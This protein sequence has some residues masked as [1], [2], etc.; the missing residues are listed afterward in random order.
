MTAMARNTCTL[1]MLLHAPHFSTNPSPTGNQDSFWIKEKSLDLRPTRT[2]HGVMKLRF[3]L[4]RRRVSR[5][6]PFRCLDL[7]KAQPVR[8]ALIFLYSRET[9][10][11][12]LPSSDE[13]TWSERPISAV[14]LEHQVHLD[15]EFCAKVSSTKAGNG[16]SQ[17]AQIA[18]I[19]QRQTLE[20]YTGELR[21]R[22]KPVKVQKNRRDNP[23]GTVL[24]LRKKLEKAPEQLLKHRTSP[25][26]RRPPAPIY[27]L[28]S[29]SRRSS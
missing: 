7:A 27:L 3:D 8:A 11:G 13:G 18:R 15:R 24:A 9:T 21:T 25:C 26:D 29:L 16:K 6:R 2:V 4:S 5:S 22:H 12:A 23:K 1:K 19:R 28:V 10:E 17:P 20:A 14:Y